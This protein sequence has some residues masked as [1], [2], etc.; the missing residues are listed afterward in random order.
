MNNTML[1]N[2]FIYIFFT[3]IATEIYIYLLFIRKQVKNVVLRSL[4]FLPSF[5]L[6]VAL[7][8]FIFG[9]ISSNSGGIFMII[10]LSLTLPKI[11]FSI[12]SMLDIPLRFFF[13][14]RIYPFTII[15][16]IVSATVL[17]IMIYGSVIG[18]TKIIVKEVTFCSPNLPESFE[19]FRIVHI[20]DL[21]LE[22]WKDTILISKIVEIINSQ[23]SDIVAFTG[24]LVHFRTSEL[25]GFEEILS[26]IKAKYGV[27][28]VLG[29]HDYGT[30]VKW[31]S[32][33]EQAEN[34]LD[35]HQRIEKMNWILLNNEHVF[36]SNGT[37]LIA[38]I[39][40][41]ND[42]E[43]RFAGSGDL[44]KAMMGAGIA[45]FKILLTHN[46]SHWRREVLDTDIDLTLAGHSHGMQF[47]IGKLSFATLRYKEWGG[48][49][50]D[51]NQGLYVNLGIGNVGIPFRFGALPEITV[52]S[53][54][55]N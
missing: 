24:D 47:A 15:A 20:S 41:E 1:S 48:M 54:S 42:G 52:I 34:L 10:Y 26:R 25:D 27:F 7:F 40:V 44:K 45:N 13:K 33:M 12:I 6:L 50:L 39:G 19:G 43:G 35:L 29:N 21:H 31:K 18:K 17:Y 36:I 2:I 16:L 38:L 46:P 49:Y 8:A 53:L 22:Y 11:T 55:K 14:L 9:K 51:G 30:Y 37:D 28:S 32:V 3:L 23:N 5:L 4:W